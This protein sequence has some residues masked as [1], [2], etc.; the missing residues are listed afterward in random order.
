[1]AQPW[2]KAADTT[3]AL[4]FNIG[5]PTPRG[6]AVIIYGPGGSGKT[7]L[8]CLIE[9]VTG[10]VVF[11]DR[12]DSLASLTSHL[13][14]LDLSPQCVGREQLPDYNATI[15][16]LESSALD[17]FP[18]V[19]IDTCTEV[20]NDAFKETLARTP[21]TENG[22]TVTSI[23]SYG[24][25]KGYRHL[26]ETWLDFKY[27]LTQ[28]RQ[29][30]KNVIL[31]A[32]DFV[33]KVPN[34]DGADYI[35]YEPALHQDGQI[36]LRRMMRDWA[37]DMVYIGFD[38]AATRE[39]KEKHAKAKG[40]GT[41]TIYPVETATCMAKSRT[42]REAIPYEYGSEAFWRLLLNKNN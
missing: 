36:S 16:F 28:L 11:A 12:D 37:D 7:L 1:M 23:E 17:P 2:K 3:P 20:Q 5:P 15:R 38:V 31:T 8:S 19:V 13:V 40:A 26:Q 32:H 9:R 33:A 42:L 18:N 41:R 21:T 25:G 10:P 30:G 14:D 24:F 6:R 29:R 4:A 39:G 34:P 35:R 22:Q 27:A